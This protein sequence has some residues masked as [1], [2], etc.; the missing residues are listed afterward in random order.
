M[1]RLIAILAAFREE[2]EELT[3]LLELDGQESLK[4]TK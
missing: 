3:K 2:V 4:L 1:P